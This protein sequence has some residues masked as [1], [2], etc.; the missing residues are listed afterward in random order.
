MYEFSNRTGS[1]IGPLSPLQSS[2][3]FAASREDMLPMAMSPFAAWDA[4]Y[5]YPDTP[6]PD[7]EVGKEAG[8]WRF[9]PESGGKRRIWAE[10]EGAYKIGYER[11]VLD[12]EARLHECVWEE[13]MRHSFIRQEPGTV[14]DVSGVQHLWHYCCCLSR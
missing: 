11:D 4:S 10:K 2:V 9:T 13:T 6:T 3:S 8:S 12:L 5:D 1:T 7:K 14:L